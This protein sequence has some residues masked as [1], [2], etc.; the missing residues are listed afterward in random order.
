[1]RIFELLAGLVIIIGTWVSVV[2]TL[3]V[4]RGLRSR[5]T[6]AVRDAVRWPF[7]IVAN[8]CRSYDAKD[9]VLAWAAPL[10]ILASLLTWLGVFVFGFGLV[11]AAGGDLSVAA[12]LREAGSSVFTLGFASGVR[13]RLTFV[14]FVAAASGPAVIGLLVGYL[15]ALY[16]AYARREA[17]VT[18]LQSRAGAP[19]WGP[20]ILVRHMQ[21][22]GLINELPDLYRGWERWSAEISES[23]TSYP[24]LIHFRSPRATRNWLIALLAVLDAAALELALNPS[25][26]NSAL[27]LSLRG[28]FVCLRDIADVE[29]ISYDPDPDPDSSISLTF[30][31]FS[32]GIDMLRYAGYRM[33]RSPEEAWPHF[34]GWRTNYEQTAYTLAYQIDAVPAPWSGPR[35]RPGQALSVVTP[36]DRQ[37]K[38]GPK[39]GRPGDAEPGGGQGQ[40]QG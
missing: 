18:L 8:R 6:R 27:R 39:L 12:G 31:E 36:V 9:R 5:H 37:P 21:I 26:P 40:G 33:E 16:G 2:S 1:M 22:P 20:E 32:Q 30:A 23:H 11:L 13:N 10:S 28:G 35:R 17:E 19:A 29:G 24:V 3:V 15:P 4:P 25:H 14:D 38:A 34:R 7:Q